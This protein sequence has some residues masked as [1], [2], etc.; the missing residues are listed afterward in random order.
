MNKQWPGVEITSGTHVLP[1]DG[2]F[3]AIKAQ[4]LAHRAHVY[5]AP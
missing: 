3:E 2:T 5:N 1:I 4:L